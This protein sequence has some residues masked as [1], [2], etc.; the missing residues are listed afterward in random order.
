M[1][2]EVE[3]ERFTRSALDAEAASGY[4]W[5]R[6]IPSTR[7]WKILDYLSA[8]EPAERDALFSAFVTNGLFL[9][10]PDRDPSLNAYQAGHPAYRRFVD[11]MP[12]LFDWKY[13]DVRLLRGVLGDLRSKSPSPEFANVPA[14][15]IR[16]AEA[17]Q[18]TNAPAIR[19]EV[20]SVFAQRFGA[21]AENRG[22]GD[23]VYSGEYAGRSFQVRIDYGG[24]SDQ[25]R[26][27]L[28]FDDV[29]TG[30]RARRL[31]YEGLIGLGDGHWDFVTADNLSES[32][33]LLAKLI[34]ELVVIPAK[35]RPEP[36]A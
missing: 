22:G 14:D 20:K 2:T 4:A 11:A 7:T 18:P 17:I 24:R 35:V 25:L 30:I 9:L 15:V 31:S 1:T 29:S 28:S 36:V 26:Y 13:V 5:L 23:W 6:R 27:G 32:V 33:L 16:R 8:I 21:Q 12:Q 19:R 10:R 3:L 34:Q